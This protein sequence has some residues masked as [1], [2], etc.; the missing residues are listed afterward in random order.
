MKK[1]NIITPFRKGGPWYWGASLAHFINKSSDEFKAQHIY[2]LS[3]IIF[4][5]FWAG[6]DIVQSVNPIVYRLWRK[7]YILTIKGNFYLEKDN[8]FSRL[9]PKAIK[10]ATVVVVPSEYLRKE[11]KLRNA[12]VI[13]DAVDLRKYRIYKR[14]VEN[15]KQLIILTV[16]KFYFQDKAMGIIKILEALDRVAKE[17]DKQIKYIVLGGGK[18]LDEVKEKAAKYKVKACFEGFQN[19]AP[20]LKK[21]DVFAYYSEHDNMPNSVMEAMACGLP[22]IVNR[23]GAIPEMIQNKKSGYICSNNNEFYLKLK[24]LIDKPEER[25]RLGKGARERTEKIYNWDTIVKEW[26]KLYD[27]I[28]RG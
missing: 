22:I 18:Y 3:D 8:P 25:Q 10:E 16:T 23:V 20:Y 21:A 1:I 28:I 6:A 5:P 26:L 14:Q 24:I 12:K 27:E 2:K 13:P 19:P 17:T 7:P 4:S 11:L 9:Y 15:K